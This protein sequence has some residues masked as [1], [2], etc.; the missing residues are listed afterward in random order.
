MHNVIIGYCA[1]VC[2]SDHLPL[3]NS[4]SLKLVTMLEPTTMPNKKFYFSLMFVLSEIFVICGID[5]RQE[6]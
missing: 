1:C 6:L 3:N 5:R 2:M 4:L